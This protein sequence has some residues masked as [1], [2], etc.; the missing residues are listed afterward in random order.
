MSKKKCCRCK[1][2]KSYDTDSFYR[3]KS[4]PDSFSRK[5]KACHK[6]AEAHRRKK[7]KRGAILD[8]DTVR[9]MSLDCRRCGNPTRAMYIAAEDYERM[10]DK[11][12]CPACLSLVESDDTIYDEPP[13]RRVIDI[14]PSELPFIS[15]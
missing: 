1:K 2:Y 9:K 12:Y 3:D 11:F 4:Q 14:R 5:C 8:E 15:T 13:S 6:I 10:K 7:G